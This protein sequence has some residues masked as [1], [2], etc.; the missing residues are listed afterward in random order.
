MAQTAKRSLT[1]IPRATHNKKIIIGHGMG[2]HRIIVVGLSLSVT[3]D[4]DDR[5]RRDV[6]D[7]AAA[8]SVRESFR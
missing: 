1:I 5:C 6:F 4:K 8:G 2:R 3:V 7:A